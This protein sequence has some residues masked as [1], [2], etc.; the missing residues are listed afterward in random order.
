VLVG[1]D[2]F[3]RPGRCPL[4]EDSPRRRRLAPRAEAWLLPLMMIG[5][6]ESDIANIARQQGKRT[7]KEQKKEKT[8][9]KRSCDSDRSAIRGIGEFDSC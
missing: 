7:A 4:G 1:N 3:H 6:P 2:G 9:I 5:V 8:K